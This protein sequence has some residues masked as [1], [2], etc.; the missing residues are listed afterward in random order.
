[1]IPQELLSFTYYKV[2]PEVKVQLVRLIQD[3]RIAFDA[4]PENFEVF[5]T[6]PL[7]TRRNYLDVKAIAI[8]AHGIH[9]YGLTYFAS[10]FGHNQWQDP[11]SKVPFTNWIDKLNQFLPSILAEVPAEDLILGLTSFSSKTRWSKEAVAKIESLLKYAQDHQLGGV[12]VSL[13][14][15]DRHSKIVYSA[16]LNVLFAPSDLVCSENQCKRSEAFLN[17]PKNV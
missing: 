10:Q 12:S 7:D 3:M 17:A 16:M 6:I 1:L 13:L 14:D 9:I 4:A 11:D 2:N 15:Y 8:W 5:V